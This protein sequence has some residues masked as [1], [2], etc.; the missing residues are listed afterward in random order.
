MR[1]NPAASLPRPRRRRSIRRA[2]SADELSALFQACP[3][4]EP[5]PRSRPSDPGLRQGDRLP[6]RGDPQPSAPDVHPT[7]SVILYE[8]FEE[9]REI[10]VTASAR[11]ARA[12]PPRRRTSTEDGETLFRYGS[13]RPLTDRHFDTIFRARRYPPAVGALARGEPALDPVLDPHRRPYD[14]GRTRRSCLRRAW[15]RSG[16]VTGLYTR[17]TFAEL[18]AAHAASSVM[19]RADEARR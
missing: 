6:T 19:G 2:L 10:P 12:L 4:D 15:R 18:Q 8:K 14:R 1:E 9:Q 11:N 17:A 3:G 7:P 16:G 13:G 5:G